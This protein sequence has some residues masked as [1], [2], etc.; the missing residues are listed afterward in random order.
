MPLA[1]GRF[2]RCLGELD[3]SVTALLIREK[4]DEHATLVVSGNPRWLVSRG[5]TQ[6]P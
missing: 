3:Q 5:L 4:S 6:Q 1:W 2:A